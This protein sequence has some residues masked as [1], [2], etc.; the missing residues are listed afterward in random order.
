MREDIT[1]MVSLAPG[2]R[3]HR[4]S[5]THPII[6]YYEVKSTPRHADIVCS[7]FRRDNVDRNHR[8]IE[9]GIVQVPEGNASYWRERVKK[10][11]SA[12]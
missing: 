9:R 8:L 7:I 4:I 3:Y 12:V 2:E 11:K 5:M 10:R 6:C 1:D